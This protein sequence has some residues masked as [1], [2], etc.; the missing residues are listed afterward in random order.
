MSHI[1][2]KKKQRICFELG[3]NIK[4]ARK[5]RK[6]QSQHLA[7]TAGISRPTLWKIEKGFPSVAIGSYIDVI[8]ALGIETDLIKFSFD[9]MSVIQQDKSD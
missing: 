8:D 4:I 6:F 2:I 3:N 1:S 9:H 7:E 5:Q